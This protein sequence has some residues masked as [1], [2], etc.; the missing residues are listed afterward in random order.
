MATGL[1][2]IPVRFRRLLINP[3]PFPSIRSRLHEWDT[4]FFRIEPHLCD[5]SRTPTA[6]DPTGLRELRS[7]RFEHGNHTQSSI[8]FQSITQSLLSLH[9]RR[10]QESP[11]SFRNPSSLHGTSTSSGEESCQSTL[12][13]VLSRHADRSRLAGACLVELDRS[14]LCTRT[15]A[16]RFPSSRLVRQRAHLAIKA[17]LHQRYLGAA[18]LRAVSHVI[19]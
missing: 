3:V 19:T 10:Y 8:R 18:P 11:T 9:D 12:C 13:E 6:R 16:F 7:S 14:C 17:I 5:V 15:S 2:F 1:I 4:S